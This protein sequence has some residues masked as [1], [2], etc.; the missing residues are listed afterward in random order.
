MGI[1]GFPD[2]CFSFVFKFW[3]CFVRGFTV[4]AAE[5]ALPFVFGLCGFAF[6]PILFDLGLP[7]LGVPKQT[8]LASLLMYRGVDS[9]DSLFAVRLTNT[10][11]SPSETDWTVDS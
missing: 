10:S 9:S 4:G 5:A 7:L 6:G 1:R 2:I 3:F 11:L 8:M